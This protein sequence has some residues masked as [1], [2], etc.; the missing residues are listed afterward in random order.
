[1]ERREG[2]GRTGLRRWK[3][4]RIGARRTKRRM[5]TTHARRR[6]PELKSNIRN[7]IFS[8]NGPGMRFVVFY[9]S[10]YFLNRVLQLGFAA[11]KPSSTS[12]RPLERERT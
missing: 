3:R 7:R 4:T 1:M 2:R 12:S 8:E 10:W 5:L 9:C 11:S 6:A